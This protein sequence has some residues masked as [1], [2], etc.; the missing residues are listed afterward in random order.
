MGYFSSYLVGGLAA[1][2]SWAMVAPAD[3]GV[4]ELAAAFGAP[5]NDTGSRVMRSRKSDRAVPASAMPRPEAATVTA[6]E[7]VGVDNAAILYRDRNGNVLY[8]TDPVRNV[9]MIAKGVKLPEVTIRNDARTTPTPVS[10]DVPTASPAKM[11]IG[12]E[13]AASPIASPQLS[14]LTGRC[15]AQAD[16]PTVVASLVR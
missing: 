9:T 5:A 10:V 16:Q 1:V 3:Y 8:R 15:L 7:V 4:S 12:C 2:V 13:P 6:I 11:P 14:H